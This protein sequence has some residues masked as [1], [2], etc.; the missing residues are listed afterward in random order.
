[1]RVITYVGIVLVVVGAIALAASSGAFDS[2]AADRGSTIETASDGSALLGLEY[3]N[4]EQVELES[5]NSDSGGNCFLVWCSDFRYNDVEIVTLEDNTPS[6]DLTIE[7]QEV[8]IDNEEMVRNNIRYDTT[9]NGHP[10]ILADFNCPAESSWSGARQTSDSGI[11][12]VSVEAS[13]GNVTIDLDREVRID[14]VQD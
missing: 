12:T 1:M 2:S 4:G 11:I 5:A 14:C 3:S 9:D 7:P 8:S 13:D 10:V 6:Q